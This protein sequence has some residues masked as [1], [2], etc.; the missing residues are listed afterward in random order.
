MLDAVQAEVGRG[1]TSSTDLDIIHVQQNWVDQFEAAVDLHNHSPKVLTGLAP[2]EV[3]FPEKYNPSQPS[4]FFLLG[5]DHAQAFEGQERQSPA[6][7]VS[8]VVELQAQAAAR[9]L[10]RASK[11]KVVQFGI[12][13]VGQKVLARTEVA[14]KRTRKSISKG[15]FPYS[16][17]VTEVI[18]SGEK[19]RLKWGLSPGP[20]GRTGQV[21]KKTFKR[22]QLLPVTHQTQELTVQLFQNADSWNS[23]ETYF[24]K[25]RVIRVFRQRKTE[26]GYLEV[27]CLLK[28]LVLPKWL[29]VAIVGGCEAYSLYLLQPK[30]QS[31]FDNC[32]VLC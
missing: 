10:K 31:H 30:V 16:G 2:L 15:Y 8:K 18:R 5:E 11:K 13:A 20:Q 25:E 26:E 9:D 17:E 1:G 28:G 29:P 12:L 19:Y 32:C 7:I 4:S 3:H 21:A 6:Q 27:L 24:A 14:G 22:D 23:Y